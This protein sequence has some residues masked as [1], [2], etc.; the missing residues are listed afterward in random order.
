MHLPLL[1]DLQSNK[2]SITQSELAT[3]ICYYRR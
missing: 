3:I 1:K 2:I